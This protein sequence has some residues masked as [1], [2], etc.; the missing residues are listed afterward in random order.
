MTYYKPSALFSVILTLCLGVF[1]VNA[2]AQAPVSLEAMQAALKFREQLANN[3]GGGIILPAD[4]LKL[5][6]RE[7]NASGLGVGPAADL[8]YAALDLGHRLLALHHPD[9]AEPF[10]QAAEENFV[11]AA[12]QEPQARDKAR[13]LQQL[14]FVR[15]NYLN[16]PAQARADI[17]EAIRLQPNNK[18]LAETRTALARGRSEFFKSPSG[19]N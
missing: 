12:S 17:D 8:G 14:A 4:A 10:F 6:Q 15:A 5:L 2:S 19:K 18:S 16:K 11:Q 13:L 3:V 1:V 9:F 7:P